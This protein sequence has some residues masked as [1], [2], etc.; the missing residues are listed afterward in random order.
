[1]PTSDHAALLVSYQPLLDLADDCVR[2]RVTPTEPT[3]F[4]QVWEVTRAAFMAR[5]ASTLRHFGYLAPSY[6]RRDGV[7]LA[8]T[9]VDHVLTF[10][11]IS[12]GP[13]ER[14]LA[15]LRTSF[16][17]LLATDERSREQG[18]PPL[19]DASRERH[20]DTALAPALGD[21]QA[22]RT[23]TAPS[24]NLVLSRE[25]GRADAPR[26]KPGSPRGS[27]RA[28]RRGPRGGAGPSRAFGHT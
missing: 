17:S 18:V 6:S 2:V 16:K 1:M 15:F 13:K 5:M 22:P 8:R 10:A 3:S 24:R 11:W 9:V 19:E 14:V 7:A 25:G 20:E 27:G 28:L 23:A 21:E 12:G 4:F 26:E